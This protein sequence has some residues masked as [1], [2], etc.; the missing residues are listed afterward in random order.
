ML[1]DSHLPFAKWLLAVA[2][3]LESQHRLPATQL[4]Q[5]IGGG[6]KTS[7]FLEHRIRAAMEVG[8]PRDPV[9]VAF[10]RS[11]PGGPL[12]DNLASEVE[13]PPSWRV[14]RRLIAGPR[15]RLSAKHLSAYW[16]EL[17]WR[18]ANTHNPTAFRDTVKALLDHAPV[19]Y[20][21]LTA[22]EETSPE[23]RRP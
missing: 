4:Q 1:H 8:A 7:W 5:V 18:E 16:N 12:D 11:V 17:L 15:G 2:V 14:L 13:A 19:P 21:Q 10:V 20:A 6:Y 9:P 23:R 22:S 3:M